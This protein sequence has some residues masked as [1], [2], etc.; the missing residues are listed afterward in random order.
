M[1]SFTL[2]ALIVQAPQLRYTSDNQTPI[3]EILVQFAGLQDDAPPETLKVV[4]WNA[5][6]Q[7]CQTNYQ[8]GDWVILEGYL[9]M[10][11]IDRSEGFKEKLAEMTAQRIHHLDGGFVARPAIPVSTPAAVPAAVPTVPVATPTKSRKSK[12][13]SAEVP[14]SASVPSAVATVPEVDYDSIPF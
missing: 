14:V 11:T 13:S 10:K 5:L 12:A 1:N 3:A 7:E 8:Q 2:L 9:S 4:A 6:A